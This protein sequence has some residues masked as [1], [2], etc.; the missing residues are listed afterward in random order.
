[1]DAMREEFSEDVRRELSNGREGE[2][3]AGARD[4]SADMKKLVIALCD[5]AVGRD[6]GRFLLKSWPL[7]RAVW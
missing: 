1:M 2:T 7:L 4:Y 6:D 5:D 3:F